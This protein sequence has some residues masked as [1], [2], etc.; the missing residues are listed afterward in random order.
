MQIK[1]YIYEDKERMKGEIVVIKIYP[2]SNY[3][4]SKKWI[5]NHVL[6]SI[7]SLMKYT[8][9]KKDEIK[10]YNKKCQIK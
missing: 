4:K 8:I 5:K 9:D 10:K 3:H 1:Y 6:T 2:I 7:K